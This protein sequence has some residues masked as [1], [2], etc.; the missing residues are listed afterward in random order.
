MESSP[1]SDSRQKVFIIGSIN[2]DLFY[3]VDHLPRKSETLKMKFLSKDLGGKGFNQAMNIASCFQQKESDF[4]I[5]FVGAVGKDGT[6]IPHL[7]SNLTP[8]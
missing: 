7:S 2:I 1:K 5:F 6:G 4:D 8:V 3:S